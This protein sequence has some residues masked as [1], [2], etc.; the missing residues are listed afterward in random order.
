MFGNDFNCP[1]HLED[2]LRLFLNGVLHIHQGLIQGGYQLLL[3]GCFFLLGSE[4]LPDFTL[5]TL[6]HICDICTVL[7]VL[8]ILFKVFFE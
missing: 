2:C 6:E 3:L 8:F 7:F 1:V 4:T 5:E